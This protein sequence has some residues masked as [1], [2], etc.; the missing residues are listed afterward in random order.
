MD[1]QNPRTNGRSKAIQIKS[2]T[3]AYTYTLTKREKGKIYIYRCSQSPL[4]QFGVIRS[5]FRYS[6]DSGYIKLIVEI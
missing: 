5:L 3:E 2:H 6:T 4:P 1:R